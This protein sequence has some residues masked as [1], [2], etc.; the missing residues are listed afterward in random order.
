M[1][2]FIAIVLAYLIGSIP[3][4]VWAGKL[5]AGIDVRE[6]GSGNA[7]ATNALRV[8]GPGIAV[9]VLLLDIAKGLFAT[10]LVFLNFIEVN[11]FIL[12]NLEEARLILGIAAVIGHIFPA[13]AR[14]KG[15]KGIA[16]FFG[17]LIGFHLPSAMFSL[18]LFLFIVSI[19]RYVSLGSIV[20]A[21]FYPIQLIFIFHI[22]SLFI[23]IFS[24][25]IP[26]IVIYTHRKNID[27]LLKGQ[28]NKISFAKS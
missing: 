24:I 7:G 15:G 28:E 9:P 4:A 12:A 16:T 18:A 17:I 22:D 5:F 8:L 20:G 25:L 2:L 27:R 23:Q 13:F 3:T 10:R 1:I 19:T 26:L 11:S 14:F 6:H 21:L